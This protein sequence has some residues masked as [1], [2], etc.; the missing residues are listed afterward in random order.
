MQIYI[1]WAEFS[2]S[3][4][5]RDFADITAA[6]QLPASAWT[7][8]TSR[9]GTLYYTLTIDGTEAAA[10]TFPRHGTGTMTLRGS[11]FDADTAPISD[12]W[13]LLQST[14][15]NPLRLDI[16]YLDDQRHL[17][18]DEYRR[19]S[20]RD[21]YQDYITG[22]VTA[23]RK[24]KRKTDAPDSTNRQGVPDVHDNHP[25][26]HYGDS[27]S[28][29]FAKFYQRPDG[30][31]KVEITLRDKAQAAALLDAYTA[32]TE[33][34][35]NDL[36]KAALVKTINFVRPSTR[37]SRRPKKVASWAAFLGSDVQPV[38][39]S[40]VTVPPEQKPVPQQ[41]KYHIGRLQNFLARNGLADYISQLLDL[42]MTLTTA[43]T[44]IQEP[45]H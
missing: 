7:A 42:E 15:S 37:H 10:V 12:L 23:D 17:S 9:H 29:T 13:C 26:I 24:R 5:K 25:L 40:A 4:K 36:A 6:L 27:D 2:H 34:A 22:T 31:C 1:H 41:L 45:Q 33:Q 11:Y 39:W 32:E 35:F 38:N 19:M 21:V 28:R 43:Y 8:T 30:L 14:G 44:T 18:V 16:S 3:L 20:Q